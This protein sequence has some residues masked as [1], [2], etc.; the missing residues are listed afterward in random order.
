MKTKRETQTQ[1]IDRCAQAVADKLC[2]KPMDVL[3]LAVMN[4]KTRQLYVWTYVD[5]IEFING[6]MECEM[7]GCVWFPVAGMAK[8]VEKPEA[9]VK[10]LAKA[11]T[12][13]KTCARRKPVVKSGKKST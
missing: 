3:T 2:G 4:T 8:R 1:K 9:K 5:P 10:R 6:A 11:S 12:K 13:P 7:L